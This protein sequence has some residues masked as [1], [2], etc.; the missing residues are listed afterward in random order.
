[1]EEAE[2]DDT[3]KVQVS[4]QTWRCVVCESGIKSMAILHMSQKDAGFSLNRGSVAQCH[5][6]TQQRRCNA[7]CAAAYYMCVTANAQCR[8]GVAIF[9]ACACSRKCPKDWR[10]RNINASEFARS[11]SSARSHGVSMVKYF[12]Q[13]TM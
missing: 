12:C 10:G 11:F 3:W 1:M 9:T 13:S 4:G 5:A 7:G 8:M 6:E 2:E